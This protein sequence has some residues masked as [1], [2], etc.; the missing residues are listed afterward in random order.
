MAGTITSTGVGSGLDVNT[1]VSSLMSVEKQPLQRLQ[2]QAGTISAEVSAYGTL[3]G[4][5]ASLADVASRLANAGN[6]N[7]M[8]ADSSDAASLS[9]SASSSAVTGQHVV[10]VQQLA[11]PQVLASGSFA[12]SQ[13]V[14]GTGKLMI[15]VGTT[16]GGAFTPRADRLPVFV[17]LTAANQTLAGVR[18]AINAASAGVTASI[19]SGAGGARLVLRSAD[20]ANSSLRITAADDDGNNSDAAGLSALAWDPAAAVGGGR[21]LS[22]T[23]AAQDAQFTIDGLALTSATNTAADALEGVTLS[24][25]RVTTAPVSLNVSVQSTAVRKNVNDFVNAYNALNSLLV[26]QTQVDPAGKKNGPLQSD[27]SA[28]GILTQLRSM[29]HGVVTGV[30]G[31]PNL[32]AA[33]IVLQ[34][35]GSLSVDEARLGPLLQSP[36]RLAQLFSQATSPGDASSA[37]FGV[38]FKKWADAVTSDAGTIGSRVSNLQ[39]SAD[40]NQKAQDSLQER[41]AATEARLRSQYQQL[42]TQMSALNARM[43]KMKSALGL[44]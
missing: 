41:L 44:P 10:T 32:N 17:T 12:S 1:I 21:N 13:S 28:V 6:W 40:R 36:A 24:L 37:G 38:R 8:V 7:P 19:V 42:D 11:Q 3:K 23:Q 30:A 26:Q 2:A 14:V 9:A 15:E 20:G 4:Q 22:Q 25:K 16:S 33:G 18:D 35:D 39:R 27:A 43:A 31:T 29:L 5:V 34:R